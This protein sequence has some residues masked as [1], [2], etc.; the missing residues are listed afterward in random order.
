MWKKK[1][2]IYLPSGKYDFDVSHCHKPTPLIID[3]K[4]LRVYFGVR[5]SSPIT[6]TTFIDLDISN[7]NS[8]KVDYIHNKPII[9]IGKIG[10]FDDSGAN[11]SSIL[12]V[13]NEIYM[14][15]IG[16]NPS[17]TVHTRNSIGL[18]KS[19]DNG[20]T[21]NRMYDG[22]ILDRNKDEPYY[23]GAV[24]VIFDEDIFK[25]WYTSGNEWKL[26][27]NKPEISY[28]IKYAESHNGIDWTRNNIDCILP[29]HEFEATARPCVIKED[30][31]YKMWYSKRNIDGF[32][33]NKAKGYRGGYAE[34]INGKKWTRLD[35]LFE[36]ELSENGWDSESIAYPYVFN[37]KGKKIMLY[38][39]NGFGKTGFG[40]A[41]YE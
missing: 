41:I 29:T 21:F 6:R 36:L 33:N 3:D 24:D 27:D 11:V 32:R 23:T 20:V 12:R 37:V 2:L 14:Y 28:R 30:G 40:Y 19:N 35:H 38:N 8:I 4:L 22:S 10:A 7:L 18:A 34:S 31:I 1:G 15:Y 16:W 17:T 13:G 39:G 25:M 26:I 9:D 5:D